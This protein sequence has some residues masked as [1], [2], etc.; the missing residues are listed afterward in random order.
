[1]YV[2]FWIDIGLTSQTWRTDA[3][4]K[5]LEGASMLSALQVNSFFI[6]LGLTLNGRHFETDSKKNFSGS[7]KI[8]I[9]FR[10]NRVQSHFW[11]NL[12][13]HIPR[14]WNKI[15]GLTVDWLKSWVLFLLFNVWH[16]N[17]YLGMPGVFKNLWF[18]ATML[19]Y[20]NE[21]LCLLVV[22]DR[23]SFNT[24]SNI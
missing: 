17:L 14:Q 11:R 18:E 8:W 13:W 23:Q 3:W 4:V 1:M 15:K 21:W 9:F 6:I 10:R 19:L 22:I 16:L 20:E 5:M 2:K 24:N 7:L 12:I